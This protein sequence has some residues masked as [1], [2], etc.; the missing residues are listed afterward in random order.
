MVKKT[1]R[2]IEVTSESREV[3]VIHH[4]RSV[5]RF[6]CAECEGTA[7][8]M[9]PE[10]AA[11]ETGISARHLYRLME[12]NQVHFIETSAGQLLV[13]LDSLSRKGASR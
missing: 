1:K 13:C 6:W 11:N 10:A 5:V 12:V 2:I 8:F 7:G 3:F 9:T 4:G